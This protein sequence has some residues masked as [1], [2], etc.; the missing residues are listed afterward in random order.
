MRAALGEQDKQIIVAH[1][2]PGQ[3]AQ[4]VAI[5]FWSMPSRPLDATK[6]QRKQS[7][8]VRTSSVGA[9]DPE[10]PAYVAPRRTGIRSRDRAKVGGEMTP[11]MRRAELH[12]LSLTGTQCRNESWSRC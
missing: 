10:D 1:G 12:R 3:Q 5:C 6:V 8:T 11:K 7:C 4:A 2:R 9:R